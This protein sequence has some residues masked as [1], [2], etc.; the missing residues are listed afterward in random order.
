MKNMI[1]RVTRC[2][3]QQSLARS[4]NFAWLVVGYSLVA[5]WLLAHALL[6]LFDAAFHEVFH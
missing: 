2:K 6:H 1:T 3:M 4:L 5:S